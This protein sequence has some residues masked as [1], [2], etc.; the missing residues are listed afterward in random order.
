LLRDKVR[1]TRQVASLTSAGAPWKDSED[2]ERHGHPPP[3]D[4]HAYKNEPT[5]PDCYQAYRGRDSAALIH[6]G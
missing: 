6:Q 2:K 3:Q 1:L 4:G 5:R